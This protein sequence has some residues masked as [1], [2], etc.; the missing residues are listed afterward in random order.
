MFAAITLMLGLLDPAGIAEDIDA[1]VKQASGG[2]FWG[3]VIVA[4]DGEELF[5]KGYGAADYEK[6]PITR[7]TV[8][9]L[10]S[11]SKQVT[12]TAVLRLAQEKK[13]ELSDPLKRF[14][15]KCPAD[16][17]DVTI[18]QL[19]NHTSGIDEEQLLPYASPASRK[20]FVDHFLD[21]PMN[22]KPGEKWV[23]NNGGY[24]LLAAIV[25]I[26]SRKSF[27][28][29]CHARLFRPAKLKRT[30][31]INDK[32]LRKGSV[33]TRWDKDGNKSPASKW[34]YGWG[35]R[36]MGG[37]CSTA[38]DLLRW[39]RA[40]RGEKVLDQASR[41]ELYRTG[42][43]H[44]AS[45]WIVEMTSS[46]SRKAHH[47]GDVSGFSHDYIRYLEDDLVIIVLSN[48]RTESREVSRAIE[49]LLVKPV[50]LRAAIHWQKLTLDDENAA[51]LGESA[52]W[53]VALEDDDVILTLSLQRDPLAVIT[54][55]VGAARKLASDLEEARKEQPD[56]E[57]TG[58]T[59]EILLA[60][61]RLGGPEPLV[62][63]HGLRFQ[64][65]P[66]YTGREGEVDD[67]VWMT[68]VEEGGAAHQRWPL[69]SRL[70]HAGCDALVSALRAATK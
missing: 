39:D 47:G 27:E 65:A 55:P 17:A 25:E 11:A 23:Y 38:A 40:L 51:R 9:E 54:L 50:R 3:A 56:A 33:A 20:E 57:E 13:L 18:R 10:A 35:Y 37:V 31:F 32:R 8:F 14:F 69:M 67:R 15:K 62:I 21:A 36:G 19:L 60:N 2:K 70:D 41:A 64:V 5:F 52:Q 53:N 29:Y 28:E 42:L 44:Y 45:G 7:D 6:A 63:E 49:Q 12:A 61:F 68:L 58:V 4:R 22:S 48:G 34:H 16:K 46:G 24:A 43:N 66:K 1:A 26:V 59:S 30:G